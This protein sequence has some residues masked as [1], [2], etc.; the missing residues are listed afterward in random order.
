[1]VRKVRRHVRSNV[2][3]YLALFVAFGGTAAA[4]IKV[5]DNSV[6]TAQLQ[7][8]A[9]TGQKVAADTLACWWMRYPRYQGRN[10]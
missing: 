7:N 4:A 9:V 2:V 3:G 6:G 10:S 1:M 8:G 5:P